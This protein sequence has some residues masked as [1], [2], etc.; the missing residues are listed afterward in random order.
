[1]KDYKDDKELT[2]ITS[3]LITS[4]KWE[5][6]ISGIEDCDLHDVEVEILKIFNRIKS[7]REN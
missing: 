2:I 6:K 4:N 3:G 1:M 5:I 7:V